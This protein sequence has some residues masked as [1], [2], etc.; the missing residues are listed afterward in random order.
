MSVLSVIA[1]LTGVLGVWL[2][3]KQNI[4]C[5][6]MALVSVLTS[7]I[8]FYYQRLYGDM[9]LQVVYLVAGIYGWA[10]WARNSKIEFKVSITPRRHILLLIAATVIMTV[11]FTY[12]LRKSGGDKP[13]FDAILTAAS[14][15]ATYMMIKKWVENWFA[16]VVIDLSYVF[17]YGIKQMWVFAVLY[18]FFAAIALAGWIKWRRATS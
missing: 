3:I 14:L 1:F 12:L 13:V 9:A 8:E 15:T 10:Y 2:T 6:P 11:M 7:M 5:W 18:F 17:L 4:L 16:W